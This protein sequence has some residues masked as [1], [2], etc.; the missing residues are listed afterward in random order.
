MDIQG[1]G[2]FSFEAGQVQTGRP[3]IFQPEHFS[4]FDVLAHLDERGDIR[5][6]YH[7]DEEMNTHVI[8]TLDGKSG[9]WY[10]A[11]Y[12]QGWYEQDSN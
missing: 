11:H 1:V 9:W 10:Q 5:L 2:T 6:E 7:F 4:L 8:D 3:D 12:S